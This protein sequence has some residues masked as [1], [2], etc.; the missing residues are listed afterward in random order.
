MPGVVWS[1]WLDHLSWHN[2]KR[3]PG[4]GLGCANQHLFPG[5]VQALAWGW[6][7]CQP[8]SSAAAPVPRG[9][10]DT[11]PGCSMPAGSGQGTAVAVPQV[12]PSVRFRNKPERSL[13]AGGRQQEEGADKVMLCPV[14]T[15]QVPGM[16]VT[17]N[18]WSSSLC[19]PLVGRVM[20]SCCFHELLSCHSTYRVQCILSC[21]TIFYNPLQ[22][23]LN[24]NKTVNSNIGRRRA[25]V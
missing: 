8:R 14:R 9:S 10:S 19:L 1:L 24:Q 3:G 5:T 16:C 12:T 25:N 2:L 17:S 11:D 15:Q 21:L 23:P 22:L 7:R 13:L 4:V 20:G 6:V 18:L